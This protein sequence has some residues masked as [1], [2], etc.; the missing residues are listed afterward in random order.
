M[1]LFVKVLSLARRSFSTVLRCLYN[2]VRLL[3]SGRVEL[4]KTDSE[5]RTHS[6]ILS[7]SFLLVACISFPDRNARTNSSDLASVSF[8][9]RI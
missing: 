8:A 1:P 9:F 2:Q 3:S 5:Q 6:L 4:E 7:R